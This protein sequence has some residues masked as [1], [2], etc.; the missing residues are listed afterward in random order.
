MEAL[1]THAHD[2]KGLGATYGF[3]LI[4][5]IAGSLCRLMEG[6]SGRERAPLFLIDAHIDAVR[7]VIR[8]DIRD[9]EHPVGRALADALETRVK[10]CVP[11]DDK[12]RPIGV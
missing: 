10:E 12:G 7:A 9:A 5:R 6:G 1:Y 3:P 8:D 11:V 4:S 2:L